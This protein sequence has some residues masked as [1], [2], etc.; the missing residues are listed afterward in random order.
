MI[1]LVRYIA[2]TFL[3]IC[4]TGAKIFASHIRAG[5]IIAENINNSPL[6]WQFTLIM[7][8]DLTS[9]VQSES[10]D[11][12]FGDG[13]PLQNVPRATQVDLGNNT[14][15]NTYVVNHT[16]NSAIGARFT[17]SATEENR[18]G[19]I[20][21]FENSINSTFHV[22][23]EIILDAAVGINATPRFTQIPVVNA[24]F[25]QTWV[26]DNGGFDPDPDDSVSYEWTVPKLSQ[27]SDVLF[28]RDPDVVAGGLTEDGTAPAFIDLD[29]VTGVIVWDAP[30]LIGCFNIAFNIVEWKKN[31]FTGEYI[32][33]STVT[34]D[35]QII[36]RQFDNLRPIIT[37]PADTCVVAGTTLRL[38]AVGIDQNTPPD[39]I[40]LSA[41]G[42]PFIIPISPAT[43][44]PN[45]NDSVTSPGALNFQ[46]NTQCIHVRQKPYRVVFRVDDARPNTEQLTGFAETNITVIGPS[47]KLDTAIV[48]PGGTIRL[49]WSPYQCGNASN[50]KIYRRI[51]DFPFSIDSCF[52]GAP[53]EFKEIG[54]VGINTFN[55]TDDDGGEGLDR[56]PK[57]CYVLVAEFPDGAQSRVSNEKC[58]ALPLDVPLI[59][60]V[61]V[62]QTAEN[63]RIDVA[64]TR[65]FELDSAIDPPPY[66]Y[67][68]YGNT[69]TNLLISKS[70]LFD[71]TFIWNGPNTLE[72]ANTAILKF[73]TNN[74]MEQSNESAS[75]VFLETDPGGQRVNLTWQA[76]VPW[77]NNGQYHL[78]Y[79]SSTDIGFFVLIDSIFGQN[80]SYSY[81]DQGQSTG[82]PLIDGNQYCY[83]VET[84]GSYYNDLFS[85]ILVNRSQISCAVPRDSI[86]PC[87]PILELSV[88][89]CDSLYANKE[90]GTD[91]A[92]LPNSNS[93]KWQPDLT[94]G[95][96]T[97]IAEYRLYYKTRTDLPYE[98]IRVFRFDTTTFEHRIQGNLAGC[99]VLTAVDSFG[100]ESAFSNEVCRD[101]CVYFALP[102]VFTP[103]NDKWNNT[104]VP[105]PE[106]QFV[107]NINFK[108]YSRWGQEVRRIENTLNIDWDG[109]STSGDPLPAGYY[110]YEAQ[111]EF[112]RLNPE[113][114]K[115]TFKGWVWLAR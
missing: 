61:D 71:T 96:D 57:Y 111:V 42:E 49:E 47:P 100:N 101:N 55:F 63:G 105:C 48:Q 77:S 60:N 18:N 45:P 53:A 80:D 114:E 84:R 59:T 106:P 79:R 54:S 64:W 51:G 2:I 10:V 91:L 19:C 28:Y 27:N 38:T 92:D 69:E 24:N 89:N 12:D 20:I 68:L 66:T 113:D 103:N 5:E 39:F 29:P 115:Q 9:N 34:R 67:E 81:L 102:N 58:A 6:S 104:F 7:Y 56:G 36:V 52:T 112:I 25:G 83:Y 99:Y 32:R 98:L 86:P 44:S 108:V 76:E 74:T 82:Q 23:S 40:Y 88:L 21:N 17:I 78:I 26:F 94:D 50:M 87:P 109:L 33:R 41:S 93:L 95:C 43:F 4:L 1:L 3:L 107:R 14:A 70:D 110:F 73:F 37:A 16:F 46:W 72:T 15:L 22:Q 65:P 97:A 85:K 35:M 30:N 90:C 62:N 75:S 11:F 31:P 8:T 13:S